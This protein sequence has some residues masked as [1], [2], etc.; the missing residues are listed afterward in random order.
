MEND[1]LQDKEC[2]PETCHRKDIK[3]DFYDFQIE[4]FEAQKKY[5]SQD[6]LKAFIKERK[7]YFFSEIQKCLPNINSNQNAKCYHN[8][9]IW[10]LGF[11]KIEEEKLNNNKRPAVQSFSCQLTK[12]QKQRLYY[13]LTE[14]GYIDSSKTDFKTFRAIFSDDLTNCNA[15]KWTDSNKLLAYLFNQMNSGSNPLI[16]SGQWQSIIGKNKLFKN[17][18]GKYL[19]AQDLATALN[20]IND[21]FK[22]LNPRGSEKIDEILENL[23]TLR[24]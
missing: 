4:K 19:T 18:A 15:V 11:Y 14:T 1:C 7:K 22:G 17:K 9:F 3:E 16:L 21:K 13:K 12:K 8:C 20:S 5:S 23:K 10:L 24:P 6:E 2:S